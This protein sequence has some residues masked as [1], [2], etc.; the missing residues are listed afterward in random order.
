MDAGL[1]VAPPPSPGIS[2]RPQDGDHGTL[3]RVLL[4]TEAS[5]PLDSQESNNKQ[6]NRLGICWL[7][8]IRAGQSDQTRHKQLKSIIMKLD[9]SITTWGF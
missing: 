3:K 4:A 7:G 9:D 6:K 8:A 2:D 1:L 5:H